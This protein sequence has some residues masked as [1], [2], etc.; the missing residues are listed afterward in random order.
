MQPA[1][2]EAGAILGCPSTFQELRIKVI[3]QGSSPL[4]RQMT[5]TF[6]SHILEAG[7]LS[8][9]VRTNHLTLILTSGLHSASL[10]LIY[11]RLLLPAALRLLA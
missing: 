8:S 6:L 7:P 4:S 3:R 10:E 9:R 1:S 2:L 5:L 11:S